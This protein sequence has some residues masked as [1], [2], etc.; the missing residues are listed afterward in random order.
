MYSNFFYLSGVAGNPAKNSTDVEQLPTYDFSDDDEPESD[1]ESEPEPKPENKPN[2]LLKT[3][4]Y[5]L[6][7]LND[8][9]DSSTSEPL[10]KPL[11]PVVDSYQGSM[12][13]SLK[14]TTD[15][16]I[17]ATPFPSPAKGSRRKTTNAEKPN[18]APPRQSL[19]SILF[20]GSK[21]DYDEKTP[22][23]TTTYRKSEDKLRNFV[24][25]TAYDDDQNTNPTDKGNSSSNILTSVI[26]SGVPDM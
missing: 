9:E 7:Q 8:T 18:T 17:M 3:F 19:K 26:K 5:F 14:S 11:R 21:D 15:M 6:K 22:T 4:G 25:L 20:S 13:D 2:L 23:D 1:P 10:F 24:F 16:D 12:Q